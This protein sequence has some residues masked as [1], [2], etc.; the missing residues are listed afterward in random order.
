MIN[1][2]SSSSFFHFLSFLWKINSSIWLFSI[3][4]R[5]SLFI[6]D[7]FIF[8]FPNLF[9]VER[10]SIDNCFIKPFLFLRSF[11]R[12]NAFPRNWNCWAKFYFINRNSIQFEIF[13]RS[14]RLTNRSFSIPIES[15]REKISIDFY[16]RKKNKSMT[17]FVSHRFISLIR[18]S[19]SI[20]SS[21][22]S[23]PITSVKNIPSTP[24]PA[25]VSLDTSL[26]SIWKIEFYLTNIW[27]VSRSRSSQMI[28]SSFS[29][30]RV[31]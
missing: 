12:S 4:C 16:L 6:A 31:G 5:W 24:V 23:C 28:E 11:Y 13:S 22:Q 26:I 18:I 14:L 15:K 9:K 27:S 1:S 30:S 21:K 19:P 29:S 7:D 20:K 25:S 8:I 2:N 3:H 10:N 17:L